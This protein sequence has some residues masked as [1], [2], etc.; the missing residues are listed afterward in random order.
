MRFQFIAVVLLG[1]FVTISPDASQATDR[2]ELL[3]F[4]TPGGALPG[5][6]FVPPEAT[7]TTLRP[8]ILFL[9]GSAEIGSD[10]HKHVTSTGFGN[11]NNLLPEVKSRGAFLY[12][13]QATS[14]G[15]TGTS[16]MTNVMTM[17]DLAIAQQ[18]V[19][20]NRVYVTGLSMGG[21]GVWNML[22]RFPDR[23]AAGVPIASVSPESGF[24]PQNLIGIP[25]WAFHAR[26]DNVVTVLKSR[27]VIDDIVAAA[28]EVSLVYP[29]L[30]D[31]T[32]TFEYVNNSLQLNYTEWPDGR[33][34]IQGRVYSTTEMYDWMFSK[35]IPEPST[36]T[37]LVVSAIALGITRRRDN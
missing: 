1:L 10:N 13:P 17:I 30:N 25:I 35:S 26:D 22:D 12:A 15:W 2:P 34:P 27:D 3:D 9:H 5:R 31:S 24:D 20:P 37:L 19:D 29:N 32:T 7:P 18:N 14:S 8:L 33:H 23:F 11:I 28:G 36:A 6:L 4:S 21:G 16:R